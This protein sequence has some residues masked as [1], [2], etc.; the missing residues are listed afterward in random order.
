MRATLT[1]FDRTGRISHQDMRSY[2]NI[3]FLWEH[4]CCQQ[5][6][7]KTVRVEVVTE[8]GAE[9][10]VEFL[11]WKPKRRFTPSRQFQALLQ[12]WVLELR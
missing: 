12:S 8:D 7:R 4:I 6:N 10:K 1:A 5:N 3:A 9:Y 11:P 2:P